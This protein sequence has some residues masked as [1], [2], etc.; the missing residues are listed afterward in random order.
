MSDYGQL[1]TVRVYFWL[2]T[3]TLVTALKQF[4]MRVAKKINTL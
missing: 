2:Q 3:Q 1:K 4:S